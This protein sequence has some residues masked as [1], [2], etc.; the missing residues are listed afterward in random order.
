MAGEVESMVEDLNLM[1]KM[2]TAAKNLSGGMK[3]KL[4]YIHVCVLCC[5]GNDR[6]YVY[7][8]MHLIK[9]QHVTKPWPIGVRTCICQLYTCMLMFRSLF[10]PQ[11]SGSR[12]ISQINSS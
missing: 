9:I 5:H 10:F 12:E 3:R 4:R 8:Y 11:A 6:F 1:D 7:I 2:K